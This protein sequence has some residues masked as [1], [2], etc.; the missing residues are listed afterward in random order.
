MTFSGDGGIR[1]PAPRCGR[2]PGGVLSA[3]ELDERGDNQWFKGLEFDMELCVSGGPRV[4][5][6]QCPP[7]VEQL[8][9]TQ[10]GYDTEWSEPFVVYA[11]YE[12]SAGG[13]LLSE[14]WAH[15]GAIL[16][17]GWVW[18]LERALWTGL[19]QDGNSFRMSLAGGDPVD[20]TPGAGA[21]DV[22]SA[23]SLLE[24]HAKDFPCSPVIH[25]PVDASAF[26][27]EKAQL[28]HE[29]GRTT[30][31]LGTPVALGSGYPL[32][33][34]GGS[35]PGAGEAWMF[36]SGG[37][38]ITTGPKFFTPERG[39]AGAAV[40]RLV[41]DV[42]VYAEKGFAVQLGCGLAAVRVRL[43]GPS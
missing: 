40:D 17:D 8:K 42:T 5:S 38:R 24:G 4:V 21:V 10:R 37:V 41:N 9:L 16:D 19:D 20:L 13:E 33:G 36:A 29:G 27:A 32:T 14:A 1:V 28:R 35:A 7:P 12:C 39:D 22:A 34:P 3:A 15:A 25:A 30:T 6:M 18:A 43:A 2:W 11:G 23:V 31:A 26:L